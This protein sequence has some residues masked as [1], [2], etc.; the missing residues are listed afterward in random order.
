M[1]LSL[2]ANFRFSFC[3]TLR[4]KR[5]RLSTRKVR[6]PVA[7]VFQLYLDDQPFSTSSLAVKRRLRI[8]DI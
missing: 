8:L 7:C 6:F 4:G 3:L 2:V 5:D 1:Q